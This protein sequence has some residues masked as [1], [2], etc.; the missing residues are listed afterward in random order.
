[1]NVYHIGYFETKEKE[2]LEQLSSI[3]IEANG[4]MHAEIKFRY[5]VGEDAKFVYKIDERYMPSCN[6][7]PKCN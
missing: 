5:A 1:M 2:E 7:F 6:S 4:E 3:R